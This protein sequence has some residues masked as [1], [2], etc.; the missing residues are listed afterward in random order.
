LNE[1]LK[2]YNKIHKRKTGQECLAKESYLVKD[3]S[4][5]VLTEFEDVDPAII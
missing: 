2:S 1:A 3:E 5:S 4:T